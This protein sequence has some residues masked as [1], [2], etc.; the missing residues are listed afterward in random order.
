MARLRIALLNASLNGTREDTSRNFRRELDADLAEFTVSDGR[1]PPPVG[2]EGFDGVVVTG[3][4]A[5]TYWDAP[6]IDEVRGW[7]REAHERGLPIL[8]VCFGHQLL[9]S[10]LGG[11]VESMGNFE[12]GYREVRRVGEATLLAGLDERFT[13]F[14][15]HGDTVTALPEGAE[16]TAENDYGLHGFRVGDAFGVQFHPEYDRETARAVTL[17][18]EFLGEERI[19]RVLGGITEENYAR[20]CE[21]KRL[22]EN[23]TEHVRR[24]RSAEPSAESIT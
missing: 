21:T 8:G 14:T 1:L 11:T 24:V 23:F 12:I 18:K 9:A 22:F 2:V 16:V 19:E 4:G 13:A 6:W 20:A 3:S 15:T 5:S 17:S 10:A 7:L